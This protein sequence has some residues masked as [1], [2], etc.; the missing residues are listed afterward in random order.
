MNM[1]SDTIITIEKEA[2]DTIHFPQQEV[3]VD[4]TQIAQRVY[5]AKRAMKLGNLFND[6]VKILFEDAEGM[7]MVESSVWG[8][9]DSYLIFKRGTM[10]PLNR[11]HE[12]II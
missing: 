11:I 10:L 3:L 7:K 6:K 9:T 2:L 12:I 4:T 8:M 1:I 5:E